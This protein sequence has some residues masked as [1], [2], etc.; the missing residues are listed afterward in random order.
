[1]IRFFHEVDPLIC[2]SEP[3]WVIVKGSQAIITSKAKKD[4]GGDIECSFTGIPLY[5]IIYGVLQVR[6]A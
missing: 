6:V 5:F 3:D 4:H 1:M 2:D